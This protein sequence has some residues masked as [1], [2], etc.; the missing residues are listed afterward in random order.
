M[1]ETQFVDPEEL[2]FTADEIYRAAALWVSDADARHLGDHLASCG[3]GHIVER[4]RRRAEWGKA[5]V[6]D[7]EQSPLHGWDYP[8]WLLPALSV[9]SASCG[10]RVHDLVAR[11]W[12]LARQGYLHAEQVRAAEEAG[13]RPTREQILA[14]LK[15][16]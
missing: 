10:A 6:P 5:G 13:T 9:L 12:T 8:E 2:P 7:A 1:S 3:P 4:D 15:Q 16:A 14:Q 11:R